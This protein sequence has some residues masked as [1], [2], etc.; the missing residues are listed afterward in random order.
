M[1]LVIFQPIGDGIHDR[2]RSD[3]LK[4]AGSGF[5]FD[6]VVLERSGANGD[7][8]GKADEFGVFELDAGPFVA[9]VEED[10]DVLRG[11]F[12]VNGFGEFHGWRA[13][14]CVQRGDANG[15]GSDFQRPK[16]AVLVVFLFNYGLESAGDSDA[17]AT[18]DGWAAFA[19]VVEEESA[20][21]FAVFRAEFENVADFN[22]GAHLEGL[23]G[24]RAGFAGLDSAQVCP[25]ADLD[26]ALDVDMA[27]VETVFVG[28]RSEFGSVAKHEVGADFKAGDVDGAQT[29]GTGA[30]CLADFFRRCGAKVG[31]AENAGEFGLVEPVGSEQQEKNWAVDGFSA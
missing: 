30:E 2:F 10:F 5:E 1:F 11:E 12:L 19:V 31:S 15:V 21:A 26:V 8:Q 17:V 29:S 14:R 3:F 7:A 9:V 13:G 28:A 18:H 20:E 24:L 27:K 25:A 16:D 22:G 6:E 4:R 23:A